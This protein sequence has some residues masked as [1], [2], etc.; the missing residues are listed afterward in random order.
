MELTFQ[1]NSLSW[2]RCVLQEVARQEETSETVVPD[3]YPDMGEIIDA[4]A[5]AV[6]RGKDLRSGSVTVSGGIKGGILYQPEDGSWPR[7]LE[8]YIP[9]TVKIECRDLTEESRVLCDVRVTAVDG[10]II[11]SRKALLRVNLACAVTAYEQA[12]QKVYSLTDSPAQLQVKQADY[13]MELPLETAERSFVI[14]DSLELPAGSKAIEQLC[15]LQCRLEVTDQKLIGARAVFRGN[16]RCRMLYLSDDHDLC[17]Q[18]FLLPF[19]QFCD[20]KNDYDMDE[21][22]SLLPVFTGYDLELESHTAARKGYLNL[23][24]LAQCQVHG[25]RNLQVLEDAFVT[26]GTLT[27]QWD[28]FLIEGLLDRPQTIQT[29]RQTM[30]GDLQQVLDTE[31]YTDYPAVERVG[32]NAVIHA[33]VSVHVLGYD[34]NGMLCGVSGKE[35]GSWELPVSENASCAAWAEPTGTPFAAAAGNGVEVRTELRLEALCSGALPVRTLCGGS[36]E[37][38]TGRDRNAPAVILRRAARGAALWD[39]AKAAGANEEALRIVNGL[40]GE[41]VPEDRVL[42]I[43][44]G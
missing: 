24:V 7:C 33:P 36:L 9:F 1:T 16:A 29:V 14:S 6:L 28:E 4:H 43:P 5:A 26:E 13:H 21:Q 34:R 22:V 15:K 30:T 17:R 12:E 23:H 27:P 31:L 25:K 35:S 44:V 38:E 11:N 8:L 10:K 42:L 18:E 19:S 20:L 39:I 2:L 37:P 3:T 41:T 32:S 40:E